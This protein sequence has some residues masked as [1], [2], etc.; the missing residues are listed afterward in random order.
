MLKRVDLGKMDRQCQREL[1]NHI[2]VIVLRRMV[3]VPE[4]PQRL[5]GK[6]SNAVELKAEHVL[7]PSNYH[8]VSKY[9]ILRGR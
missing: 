1:F 9:H 5:A 6:L 3:F 2:L 7:L 4:L 8:T